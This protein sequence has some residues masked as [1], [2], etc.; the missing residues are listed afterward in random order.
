MSVTQRQT[1]AT[2]VRLPLREEVVG[3]RMATRGE[4]SE[5][6]LI[7]ARRTIDANLRHAQRHSHVIDQFG[8]FRPR[9]QQ[10]S[11]DQGDSTES[12][13]TDASED[14]KASGVPDPSANAGTDVASPTVR[15][16]CST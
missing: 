16:L 3:Q 7:S 11:A 14:S 4:E 12:D 9:P 1:Q 15:A 13:G 10:T 2:Q 5:H 8:V 6:R